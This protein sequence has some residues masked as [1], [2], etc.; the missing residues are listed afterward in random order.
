MDEPLPVRDDQ[1]F[2]DPV[3]LELTQ[4]AEPAETGG[5]VR[6]VIIVAL[7][8]M[9]GLVAYRFLPMA[10]GGDDPSGSIQSALSGLFGDE[11][12]EP[13]AAA[14]TGG[15]PLTVTGEAANETSRSIVTPG[16]NAGQE[17]V[18]VEIPTPAPTRPSLPATLEEINLRLDISERT[19][20]KITID[21]EDQFQGIAVDGEVFEYRALEQAEVSVGNGVGVFVTINGIELGRLGGRG[22]DYTETWRTTTGG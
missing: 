16:A 4:M 5:I 8:A 20:L 15:A 22:Q 9:I 7:V 14:G 21:G 6:L 12:P 10:L 13:T 1:P 2:F 18:V 3:N 11:T 17:Q 19:W